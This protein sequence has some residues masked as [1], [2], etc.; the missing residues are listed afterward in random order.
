MNFESKKRISDWQERINYFVY[1]A[2]TSLFDCDSEGKSLMKSTLY[3]VDNQHDNEKHR[4]SAEVKANRLMFDLFANELPNIPQLSDAMAISYK[5]TFLIKIWQYKEW[6]NKNKIYVNWFKEF[7]EKS[8]YDVMFVFLEMTET[9]IYKYFPTLNVSKNVTSTGAKVPNKN[10]KTIQKEKNYFAYTSEYV[11]LRKSVK[12]NYNRERAIEAVLKKFDI[13]EKTL[14]RAFDANR[15]T[16]IK[17][18][19]IEKRFKAFSLVK[20]S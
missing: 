6:Y 17:F 1:C 3:S 7:N 12:P 4:Y 5:N 8:I 10:P 15:E 19:H 20:W 11:E 18:G 13:S 16:L 14:G 2:T 9:E